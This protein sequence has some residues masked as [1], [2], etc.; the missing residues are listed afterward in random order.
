AS[1]ILIAVLGSVA[2]HRIV[3]ERDRAMAA[4]QL[5]DTRRAAAEKLVDYVVRDLRGR[6][7]PIGRID[8]LGG[9]GGGVEDYYAALTGVVLDADDGDRRALALDIVA[10]AAKDKGDLDGALATW[11]REEK[12]LEAT[13]IAHPGD[14]A[15]RARRRHA[16][17]AALGQGGVHQ[18]RGKTELAV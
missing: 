13:V 14:S 17:D 1:T 10:E 16:A 6:L 5:A 12:E 8:L 3:V 9:L 11:R 7:E 2:I 18:A 15:N 4:R